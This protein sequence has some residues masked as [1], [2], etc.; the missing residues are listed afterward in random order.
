MFP[1]A[2]P[3]SLSTTAVAIT[4]VPNVTVGDI[5]TPSVSTNL[6]I[7]TDVVLTTSAS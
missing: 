3:T 2:A 7:C 4:A 6:V 5:G 1:P